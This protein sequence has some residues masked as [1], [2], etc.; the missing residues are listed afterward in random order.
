V[1]Q[2][3]VFR[4]S[5]IA[6]V[7]IFVAMCAAQACAAKGPRNTT[8]VAALTAGDLALDVDKAERDIYAAGIKEYGKPQHDA[9]GDQVLKVL[10]ATRA[11]ERASRQWH[12]GETTPKAVDDAKA[13]LVAA[14][15]DLERVIPATEAVRT[16]L[17]KAL[18]ALKAYLSSPSAFLDAAPP[19]QTAE[20]P[21]PAGALA[22][23]AWAQLAGTLIASGR[24]SLEKLKS[25]LQREGATDEELDALDVKLTAAIA[26]READKS[27][28]G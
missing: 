9:V 18:N 10:Y 12:D 22:I 19:L 28:G 21:L 15:A 1:Q 11:F 17:L 14:I 13:A 8:R 24:S 6:L 20:L 27:A 4:L 16:P 5:L 2:R 26:Q 7:G 25:A 23:L 3:T